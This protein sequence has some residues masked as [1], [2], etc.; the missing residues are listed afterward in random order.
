MAKLTRLAPGTVLPKGDSPPCPRCGSMQTVVV[1]VQA[2]HIPG[3]LCTTCE[4]T[5]TPA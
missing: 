5:W 2:W 3:C 1:Q 4:N